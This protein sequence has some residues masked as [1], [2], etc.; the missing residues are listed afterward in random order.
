MPFADQ[1]WSGKGDGADVIAVDQRDQ[2]RPEDQLDLERTEAVLVQKMRNLNFRLARHRFPQRFWLLFNPT[3]ARKLWHPSHKEKRALMAGDEPASPQG[4]RGA[5]AAFSQWLETG[6]AVRRAMA[7]NLEDYA[8]IGDCQ[9]AALVGRDGSI[10]WLCWPRLAVALAL[11]RCS[12]RAI[13]AAGFWVLPIPRRYRDSTLI[14]ET[15]IETTN[16][17]ATVTDFMP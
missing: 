15:D 3:P 8:L 12:A 14:L 2:D 5:A 13:T 17:A 10:D 4:T 1:V 7:A 16:G 6:W 9:T 11:R